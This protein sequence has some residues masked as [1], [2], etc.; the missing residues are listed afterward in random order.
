MRFKTYKTQKLNVMRY[1]CVMCLLMF[2]LLHRLL[3]MYCVLLLFRCRS[4]LAHPLSGPGSVFRC[5]LA[6]SAL[7]RLLWRSLLPHIKNVA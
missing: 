6:F 2:L 3:L 5:L 7:T 1:C 4:L